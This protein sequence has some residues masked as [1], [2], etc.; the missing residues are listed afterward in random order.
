M[1]MLN[2]LNTHPIVL[3]RG[4]LREQRHW[5]DFLNQLN[6]QFPKRQI[7]CVDL[8]GNGKRHKLQSPKSIPAMVQDLRIQLR[9]KLTTDTPVDLIALSMGGM[10]A[11]SW[12][13]LFPAEIRSAILMNT[14]VRPLSPFYQRLNWRQYLT[15]V[16]ML[17][18]QS[19]QQETLIFNMTS[20]QPIQA[21]VIKNWTQW[22]NECPITAKNAFNQLYTSAMFRF[23]DKPKQPVMLLGSSNDRLVSHQ[24]SNA[25]SKHAE[26]PLISHS[27]AGH[28]LT[29]DEPEWVSKQAAAFYVRLPK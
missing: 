12:M 22:K 19:E 14:S 20:N 10:I 7:I 27:T 8:A 9:L 26:W 4:L 3:I 18:S 21:K 25:L 24:C 5:G 13:T 23:T 29:L 1:K 28:D 6:T 15:I 16:R 17:L 2:A 11:I